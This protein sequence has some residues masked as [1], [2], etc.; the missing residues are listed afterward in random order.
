LKGNQKVD[1]KIKRELCV[2]KA[3]KPSRM[4]EAILK[5]IFAA[6]F[7][8]LQRNPL[9]EEFENLVYLVQHYWEQ[10]YKKQPSWAWSFILTITGMASPE[11]RENLLW[12]AQSE[13]GYLKFL[14]REIVEVYKEGFGLEIPQR[15]IYY[16]MVVWFNDYEDERNRLFNDEKLR[17]I[18]DIAIKMIDAAIN[19]GGILERYAAE[20]AILAQRNDALAMTSFFIQMNELSNGA[21]FGNSESGGDETYSKKILN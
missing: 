6:F 15:P 20:M 7:D 4:K 13:E 17:K 9:L 8:L 5:I 10:K 12:S 19:N 2:I 18:Y 14:C 3:R 11:L 16:G 21:L 1:E